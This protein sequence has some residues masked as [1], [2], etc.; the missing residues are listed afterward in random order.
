MRL[1]SLTTP[2]YAPDGM[3]GFGRR[4][5]RFDDGLVHNHHWAVSAEEAYPCTRQAAHSQ[6]GECHHG[7][8]VATSNAPWL[9]G[10]GLRG[11]ELHGPRLGGPGE[12]RQAPDHDD[13]LVHNHDWAVTAR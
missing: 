11:P 4:A 6:S 12:T 3:G 2:L 7:D 10:P 5:E 13:G 8:R 1:T 9:G